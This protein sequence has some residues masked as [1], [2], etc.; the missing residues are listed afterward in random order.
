MAA[1]KSASK[2]ITKKQSTK[3][4]YPDD[5]ELTLDDTDINYA[6]TSPPKKE[7]EKIRDKTRPS[8][9]GLREAQRNSNTRSGTNSREIG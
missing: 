7:E 4:V 6:V 2:K 9:S 3:L 5:P 8:K 1:K